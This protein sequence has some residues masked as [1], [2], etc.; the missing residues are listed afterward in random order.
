MS[1]TSTS[2][3]SPPKTNNPCEFTFMLNNMFVFFHFFHI[4][5][6]FT[7]RNKCEEILKSCKQERNEEVENKMATSERFFVC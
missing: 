2:S 4:N 6:V 3:S 5:F 1:N 7:N